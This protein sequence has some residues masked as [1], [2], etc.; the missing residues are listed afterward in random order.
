[1]FKSPK[2]TVVMPAYSAE[3]TLRGVYQQISKKIVDEIILVDDKSKDNTVELSK[4]LGLRTLVH[5][6]NLGY[7]ANQKTCYTE[8]LKRGADLVIMLHPDG[9]Y[10][11]KDLPKFINEFKKNHTDLILGSRFLSHGDK[12]TP[13]Y[14]SL[15]IRVITALFNLVLGTHLSE[16][17]T[18]YRSFSRKLLQTIPW[19]K[20]GNGYIF[21]PQLIIQTKQYGFTIA[22]VPIFKDYHEAASSPNFM[23]SL[24]HGIENLQLLSEYILHR[25]HLRKARFL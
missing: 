9:Q 24:R 4:K 21:D 7:G 1:M 25:L 2:I 5:K 17:N 12:K 18:G 15:S 19:Q 3:K 16:A 23:T 20:N 14:K 6:R 10:D 11:P 13:L 22:D 8:A